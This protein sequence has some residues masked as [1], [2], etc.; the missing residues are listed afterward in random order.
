MSEDLLIRSLSSP[1]LLSS[2]NLADWDRLIPAARR[3]GLLGRVE[4]LLAQCELLDR[5]PP[6]ARR[7]L[8]SA[9]IVADNEERVLL[10]EINRL[11]RALKGADT[12]VVLLKGAAYALSGLSVARGRFSTDVDVLVARSEIEKIEAMLLRAGWRPTKLDEYDQYFYRRW[13]HELPPLQHKDRG[14]VVDVHHTIL[15]PTGRLH[16]DPEKLL[17]AS[18]PVEGTRFRVLAP[19]DMVLHSAAHAFQDGD[20]ARGLRDLV[21]VDGLVR[22]FSRVENFWE[23]LL[24]RAEELELSRPLFYALRYAQRYLDTPIAEVIWKKRDWRPCRLALVSMDGLVDGALHSGGSRVKR[25][26]NRLSLR[27]LYIRSHWLRMPPWLLAKHLLRQAIR[28][29]RR[30]KSA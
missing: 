26:W 8:E 30:G 7:H 2:L 3:Q 5:V 14:T 12:R 28:R 18:V 13:S 11:E 19:L 1:D 22:H 25:F 24:S 20:L 17:A 27:L 15:P 9:R 23:P 4:A 16:P 6:P 10:W 21:D 29:W